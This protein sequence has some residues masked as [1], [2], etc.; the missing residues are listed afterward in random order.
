[1][2]SW[3]PNNQQRM[4]YTD[5]YNFS[6]TLCSYRRL[7]WQIFMKVIKLTCL[8]VLAKCLGH[9]DGCEIAKIQQSHYNLLL[10]PLTWKQTDVAIIEITC[11]LY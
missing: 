4:Y 5:L 10:L 8:R 7:E 1:M 9:A 6:S 3:V 11:A 2:M